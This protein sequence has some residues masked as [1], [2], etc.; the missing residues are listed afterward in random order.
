MCVVLSLGCTRAGCM[1]TYFVIN[2]TYFDCRTD[3]CNSTALENRNLENT[4]ASNTTDI[5]ST[6]TTLAECSSTVSANST[7]KTRTANSNR[8]TAVERDASEKAG[9]SHQGAD[10]TDNMKSAKYNSNS[11]TND[12][13][14]TQKND[15]ID[16][17]K[18][19]DSQKPQTS[20][21]WRS[22]LLTTEQAIV[23]TDDTHTQT[24]DQSSRTSVGRCTEPTRPTDAYNMNDSVRPK[25]FLF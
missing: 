1:Y 25:V 12:P 24:T 19:C 13:K 7:N 10:D 11:Q 2:S 14:N 20:S 23:T 5:D 4:G 22:N 21:A 3:D 18:A 15:C 8:T 17:G 16:S 9:P 6:T